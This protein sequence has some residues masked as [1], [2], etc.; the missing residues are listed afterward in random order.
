M[1]A[2]KPR[3]GMSFEPLGP[4]A[5]RRVL[6]SADLDELI[7]LLSDV[8]VV[9]YHGRLV[10][11]LD[12]SEVTPPHF[13][14]LHDRCRIGEHEGDPPEDASAARDGPTGSRSSPRHHRL[15]ARLVSSREATQSARSR[16]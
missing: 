2:P 10:A 11:T 16:R 15:V 12:P 14:Q 9:M 6:I 4:T 3:S 1:S 8:I 7:G 13:R 5:W